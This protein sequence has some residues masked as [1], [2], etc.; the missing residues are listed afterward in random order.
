[1]YTPGSLAR[2]AE[3]GKKDAALADSSAQVIVGGSS[4]LKAFGKDLELLSVEI[5][6]PEG[7][8]V[9]DIK[10][11]APDPEDARQREEGVKVW[12]VKVSADKG[13]QVGKRSIVLNQES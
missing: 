6:P 1:L 4:E 13:A 3:K 10:E 5:V 11:T 12:S 9:S 2:A 8:T 7:V